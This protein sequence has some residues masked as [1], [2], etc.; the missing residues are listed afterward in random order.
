[1]KFL[2]PLRIEE[3]NYLIEIADITNDH[4]EYGFAIYEMKIV[5]TGYSSL[6]EALK[7]ALKE[8]ERLKDEQEILN[9]GTTD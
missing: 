4:K 6:E 2:N 5:R 7:E 3:G 8:L 9:L 1:M